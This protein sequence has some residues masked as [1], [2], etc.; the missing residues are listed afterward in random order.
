MSDF[1]TV[2]C[3]V[4]AGWFFIWAFLYKYQLWHQVKARK[5]GIHQLLFHSIKLF[6]LFAGYQLDLPEEIVG[7]IVLAIGTSLPNLFV[8]VFMARDGE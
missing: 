4:D 6:N 2:N 7:I 5:Y 3:N 1:G 8:S